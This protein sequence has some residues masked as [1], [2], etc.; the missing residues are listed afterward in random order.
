MLTLI[1]VTLAAAA[2]GLAAWAIDRHRD[3]Y[4]VLLLPGISVSA[5]LLTWLGLQVAGAA[6]FEADWIGWVVPVAVSLVAPAVAAVLIG[7]RRGTADAVENERILR[8]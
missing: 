4:G 6:S 1:L 2:A 5:A 3:R 7:R 8:L